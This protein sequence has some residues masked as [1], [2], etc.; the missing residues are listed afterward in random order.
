MATPGQIAEV[1]RHFVVC[2]IWA[3]C[4]EGTHPRATHRTDAAAF[5]ICKR[6]IDAN[7]D[8]FNAAMLRCE[9]GYGSHPDAGSAEAAFGHDL[10]LSLSGHGAG[11]F[12]RTE[13]QAEGLGDALQ[14]ACRKQAEPEHWQR[15]GWFYIAPHMYSMAD[16]PRVSP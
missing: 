8:L 15:G 9:V 16:F 11:F 6:F 12:D 2:A 14:D 13:L 10:W 7:H 4:E 1:A 3:D 5:A